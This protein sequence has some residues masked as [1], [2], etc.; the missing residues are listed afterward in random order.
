MSPARRRARLSMLPPPAA[1]P[2]PR[3]HLTISQARRLALGAQGFADPRP[4][5]RVDRRHVRRVFDRMGVLQVDSVNV[6]ARSEQLP[7]LAR[8][9]PH[10]TDLVRSMESDGE[11]FEYWVHEA[12]LAPVSIEPLVR[13]KMARAHEHAWT[14]TLA[15]ERAGFVEEVYAEIAER[16]PLRVSELTGAT[17]KKGSWWGWTDHKSAVE[18]L[19]WQGRIA[20]TRSRNNFERVYDIRERVLPA[21][22]LAAPTPTEHDARKELLVLAAGHCGVGDRK[23]VV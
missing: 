22:I 18:F 5:A 19:F 12:S 7:M 8:L 1:V 2:S 20:G 21:S 14:R 3:R 16:G 11:L 15:T 10:R 23:S 4:T 6:V 17:T 13:W 9:G